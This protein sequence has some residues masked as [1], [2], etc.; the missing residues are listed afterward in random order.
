MKHLKEDKKAKTKSFFLKE[1]ENFFSEKYIKFI[2]NFY[3]KFKKDVRI[4]L[5]KNNKSKHHDMI[6][7]QQ[8]KNFYKPHKHKLKGETYHIIS[9]SMICIIFKDS[10]E[11]QK[12]FILKKNNIFRTPINRY[13]TMIPLSKYV[14][15]HE[16]RTGPFLKS[17]SNFPNWNKKFENKKN[18]DILKKKSLSIA[19]F[20]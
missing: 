2:K 14:I 8:Q 16:S 18:I 19:K 20:H 10:G 4:C 1:K 12:S 5:H 3:K 9:G 15:F 13:H 11:I 17:D 7:L 6:I